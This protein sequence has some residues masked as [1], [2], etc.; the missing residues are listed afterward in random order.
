MDVQLSTNE[1]G[2]L[3]GVPQNATVIMLTQSDGMEFD[4]TRA[5]PEH[6]RASL[7]EER[8]WCNRLG[9]M[10]GN[11]LWPLSNQFVTLHSLPKHYH[12]RA[13]VRANS[14]RQ[15]FYCYG[16]P[17]T[18]DENNGK[19]KPALKYYRS[20]VDF[21][22]HLLWLYSDRTLDRKNCTC[23]FCR[24][25]LVHTSEEA[26]GAAAPNQARSGPVAG[27]SSAPG[28]TSQVPAPAAIASQLTG[29]RPAPI[30]SFSST[31]PASIPPFTHPI[32]V[33]VT[34]QETA[35][36]VASPVPAPAPTTN[37]NP[38]ALKGG[39]TTPMTQATT[40][41]SSVPAIS[42]SINSL[43]YNANPV[44]R[45]PATPAQVDEFVLFRV[46]E[47]VWYTVK[48]GTFRLGVI[49]QYNPTSSRVKPL[50]HFHRPLDN[51]DVPESN[52]RPFL[53]YSV[54]KVHERLQGLRDIPM[55]EI[56]WAVQE[57]QLDMHPDPRAN[58]SLVSIEA[59]KMG[60]YHIDHSYSLFNVMSA[61]HLPPTQQFYGG[62][63]FGCEKIN[64]HEAVR[65]HVEQ[66]EHYQWNDNNL[67]FAMVVKTIF[68]QTDNQGDHLR[69]WGDIWLLQ[70]GSASSPPAVYPEPLPPA[71]QREKMFQDNVKRPYG[72]RFEWVRI[73][74]NVVKGENSIRGRFYESAKLGPILYGA[75][76]WNRHV[77]TGEVPSIQK[78]LN[79]RG[80]SN[81]HTALP[82]DGRKRS[83]MDALAG[84]IP[85][86][87]ALYLGSGVAEQQ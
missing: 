61:P 38:S 25:P 74:H 65:V 66:N 86:D 76:E 62:V 13:K 85:N 18:E 21:F 2:Q 12:I 55:H 23:K 30:S 6:K 50:S 17:D 26:P 81:D 14:K 36:G 77:G 8:N 60:A 1:Q 19:K 34:G 29:Q 4:E 9:S 47:I 10:I 45:A 31:N 46:G 80:D 43:A 7:E 75:E 49:L 54:P 39:F 22:P 41:S 48:E 51:I 3:P 28:I 24:P 16:Y 59:S 33:P 73:C 15:D 69:F 83:R 72:T 27:S 57:Q 37:Q 53:T 40:A 58:I 79:N 87:V 42:A 11:Q 5:R 70:E 56:D 35:P 64:L 71:M 20:C 52:M 82:T 84:I 63:F 32:P 44:P 78:K 67:I 68:I